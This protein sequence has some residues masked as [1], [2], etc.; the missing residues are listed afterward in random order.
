VSIP[1]NNFPL[2]VT[3]VKQVVLEQGAFEH[4]MF[5]DSMLDF[6]PRPAIAPRLDYAHFLRTARH[7]ARLTVAS[8]VAADGGNTNRSRDFDS[9]KRR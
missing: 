8:A 9:D 5:A 1:A 6:V 4:G 3:M 2:E 7:G